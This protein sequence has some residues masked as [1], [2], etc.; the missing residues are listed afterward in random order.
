MEREALEEALRMLG[1]LLDERGQRVGVL[2]AGGGGL[3]LLG[4]VQRPTADVDV[5][6]FPAPAGYAKADPLPAFLTTAVRE[7]GDA[8]GL[9]AA[10]LNNGP[11]ALLDLGLPAGL[12]ERVTVRTYGGLEVHLPDRA[13]LVAFKLYAAADQGVRSKHFADLR[14]LDPTRD[15]LLDAARWTRTHD[16]SAPF[17][18]ELRGVL[19]ALGV[20]VSD[21]GL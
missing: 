19:A 20:A 2:V 10:W 4:I 18:A 17:L 21:A 9:G 13:D 12:A 8:L 7:V 1:A 11:A 16:P 6:G 5:I 14:A 15:Q 3:L